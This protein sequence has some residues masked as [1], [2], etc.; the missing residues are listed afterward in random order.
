MNFEYDLWLTIYMRL[1]SKFDKNLSAGFE[2]YGSIQKINF[3]YICDNNYNSFLVLN[4]VLCHLKLTTILC[5]KEYYYS[6]INE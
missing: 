3:T 1:T 2:G 6:F 4:Y 5:H